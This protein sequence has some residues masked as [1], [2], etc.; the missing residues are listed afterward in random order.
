MDILALAEENF[1]ISYGVVFLIGILQGAI[2]GRGIRKRFPRLKIHA[3]ITSIVLLL[4]FSINAIANV[5]KFA[6]P[7]KI[8]VSEI[9]VPA[10]PEEGL[11]FLINVLGLNAGFGTIVALFVSIT[12]VL[13]FKFA[14][15]PNVARYFM[16][17]LSV[18]VLLVAILSRFTEYVPSLFQ[19]LMYAFYQ[20]GITGGIFFVTRRRE[21]EEL[22]DFK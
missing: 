13:F 18:I 2:L 14:E 4:L 6:I 20:F 5:I 12:L 7:E 9:A 10:T 11:A 8:T 22:P 1:L 17:G 3:R 15:I 21:R 16:F 19:V